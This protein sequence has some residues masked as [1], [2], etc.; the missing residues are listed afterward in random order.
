[1]TAGWRF[2]PRPLRIRAAIGAVAGVCVQLAM[3]GRAHAMRPFDGTDAS[4]AEEGE[5]E[6]ELGP[7]LAMDRTRPN[8][9]TV[10]AMAWNLGIA[11]GWEMSL[12]TTATVPFELG[13]A[14]DYT[15]TS[16][17][18]LKTMLREGSLQGEAGPSI[19]SE[20]HLV[21]PDKPGDV[22]IGSS[23][24]LLVSNRFELVTLHLNA[25]A[26][27]AEAQSYEVFVGFIAEASDELV[28]RPVTEV[29][30]T[31]PLDGAAVYSVLGGAIW[32]INDALSLDAATVG[33]ANSEGEL[34]SEVR[35]G[36]TWATTL[37][38]PRTSPPAQEDHLAPDAASRGDSVA[39]C[40][41]EDVRGVEL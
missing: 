40:N 9:L 32:Q 15:S 35:L 16:E 30:I 22:G 25:A 4:V 23:L 21:L 27:R 29:T 13:Q 20:V 34:G 11:P 14:R 37:W 26:A 1:V 7:S 41:F 36:F 38:H 24:A 8:A 18:S 5:L 31:R 10:P 2:T 33:T 12:D 19:A 28:V 3:P 39:R 6:L 17:L